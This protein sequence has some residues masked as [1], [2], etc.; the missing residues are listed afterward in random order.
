MYFSPRLQDWNFG[1]RRGAM[2]AVLVAIM[3]TV[4]IVAIVVVAPM[5]LSLSGRQI[6]ITPALFLAMFPSR[7][8]PMRVA[9]VLATLVSIVIISAVISV[10][11]SVT[12]FGT[13]MIVAIFVVVRERRRD[14]QSQG[15]ACRRKVKHWSTHERFS[16]GYFRGWGASL[17]VTKV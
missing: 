2:L 16:S 3:V 10:M 5:F 8:A 4:T 12:M 13:V 17:K 1:R 11:V 14:E 15:Q 6:A 7:G 9:E